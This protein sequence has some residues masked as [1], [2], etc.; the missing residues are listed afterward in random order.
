MANQSPDNEKS[1]FILTQM[2]GEE[3][4]I[5]A[6]TAAMLADTFDNVEAIAQ[7]RDE[8]HRAL[9]HRIR[10]EQQKTG[11][12]MPRGPLPNGGQEDGIVRVP[13]IPPFNQ[14]EAANRAAWKGHEQEHR[15]AVNV[16]RETDIVN[17]QEHMFYEDRKVAH[18]N[19]K[20]AKGG[21]ATRYSDDELDALMEHMEAILPIGKNEWERLV[22]RYNSDERVSKDRPRGLDNLRSQYNKYAKKKAPTGD[23]DCPPLVKRAKRVRESIRQKA[24]PR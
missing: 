11:R 9:Q 24:L 19:K 8:M 21:G 10:Q 22:E 13:V 1:P 14:V 23:P 15:A 12:L 7:R 6:A 18:N 17:R 4:D 2:E 3:L 16:A 20:M 5:E